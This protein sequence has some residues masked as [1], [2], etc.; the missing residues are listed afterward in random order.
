[1]RN[2][3]ESI[4]ILLRELKT[5]ETCR[6]FRDF[7]LETLTENSYFSSIFL[8][9]FPANRLLPFEV[10]ASDPLQVSGLKK[11]I[12][13]LDT[14]YKSFREIESINLNE[15]RSTLSISSDFVTRAY[16]A[17]EGLYE[18][19]HLINSS[20]FEIKALIGPHI[21]R[22]LQQLP[23]TEK[24]ESPNQ[25]SKKKL[26]QYIPENIEQKMVDTLVA[27][28]K[29][30]PD[31]KLAENEGPAKLSKLVFNLPFYFK[32]L[33]K[34]L[35]TSFEESLKESSPNLLTYQ[36]HFRENT[37]IMQ[38]HFATIVNSEGLSLFP[39]YFGVAKQLLI[40]SRELMTTAAPLTKIGHEK[41]LARLK[42]IRQTLLPAVITEI[43]NVEEMMALKPG[44]LTER[45]IFEM[46][47]YYQQLVNQVNYIAAAAG[48]IEHT[49][50]HLDTWYGKT[51]R[52]LF[53]GDTSNFA[54]GVPLEPAA[55]L[56]LLYNDEFVDQLRQNQIRRI[57]NL[58]LLE[59]ELLE[60]EAD[61]LRQFFAQLEFYR[62]LYLLPEASDKLVKDI[63]TT[64]SVNS[65]LIRRH[66]V[67][68][69]PRIQHSL[70]KF[71]R[72]LEHKSLN[73]VE[74]LTILKEV[75][76]C[77][78]E[79]FQSITLSL[80][81]ADFRRKRIEQTIS[82]SET[83][84]AKMQGEA[85]SLNFSP[86][87][88]FAPL[89][90]TTPQSAE[91]CYEKQLDCAIWVHN[92]KIAE[93][94]CHEFD[95]YLEKLSDDEFA[96][97]QLAVEQ[98]AVLRRLYKDFQAL[99]LAAEEQREKIMLAEEQERLETDDSL[100]EWLLVPMKLDINTELVK[101]LR[102]EQEIANDQPPLNVK[103]LRE[104]CSFIKNKFLKMHLEKGATHLNLYRNWNKKNKIPQL[105]QLISKP[106]TAL[107]ELKILKLS[108][109]IDDYIVTDLKPFLKKN[110]SPSLFELI[111]FNENERFFQGLHRDMPQVAI[112][113]RLLNSLYSIQNILLQLESLDE[114]ASNKSTGLLVIDK[115]K[116]FLPLFNTSHKIINL[117]FSFN[118][119]YSH[120]E[121]IRK[122]LPGEV[123]ISKG[124]ELLNFLQNQAMVS[125]HLPP[126]EFL[127][128]K[129]NENT[130]IDMITAWQEQQNFLRGQRISGHLEVK[131]SS[132]PKKKVAAVN[133]SALEPIVLQ[134][135]QIQAKLEKLTLADNLEANQNP[136]GLIREAI[137]KEAKFL[138]EEIHQLKTISYG[139]NSV[140]NL[141]QVANKINLLLT[142][143][144]NK[145]HHLLMD[146]FQKPNELAIDLIA[147]LQELEFDFGLKPG[148][149]C[150]PLD[151]K[152]NN[153]YKKTVVG[154]YSGSQQRQGL[155]LLANSPRAQK[156]LANEQERLN[157]LAD[158]KR[159]EE[160]DEL[161]N[162]L[163]DNHKNM[164]S[165]YWEMDKLRWSGDLTIEALA[166][167]GRTLANLMGEPNSQN[168]DPRKVS[169]ANIEELIKK[170]FLQ[171][172]EKLQPYLYQID[173]QYN[174][175]RFLRNLETMENFRDAAL[176]IINLEAALGELI[177]AQQITHQWQIG[178]CKER[179]NYFFEQFK[180][181]EQAE[182]Q[183]LAK[184]KKELLIHYGKA[185]IERGLGSYTELFFKKIQQKLLAIG[186]EQF[187]TLSW[188]DNI[189]STIK[190]SMPNLI[191]KL[192]ALS[193]LKSLYKCLLKLRQVD[194]SIQ[195][196][197]NL[198]YLN[199][200]QQQQ[201]AFLRSY[202]RKL[203]TTKK[204]LRAAKVK[205]APHALWALY[206]DEAKIQNKIVIA[207][208]LLEQMRS[209]LLSKPHNPTKP[210]PQ[211]EKIS[212][213][214]SLMEKLLAKPQTNRV[215]S[216]PSKR[217]Q[218]VKNEWNSADFRKI[219]TDD[220][221][222][223]FKRLLKKLWEILSGR[224]QRNRFFTNLDQILTTEDNTR[225]HPG[226][227]VGNH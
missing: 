225:S 186:K 177:K 108:A 97:G 26:H 80:N 192:S 187:A 120:F 11:I 68:L 179:I 189:E 1:M 219:L 35:D 118:E 66:L 202:R 114:K 226:P 93:K 46:N 224:P 34:L 48:I 8:A 30:L 173:S 123:V 149:L 61:T 207:Y 88:A 182:I 52:Q 113:K 40:H 37:E 104:H 196:L 163:M 105:Q 91:E 167:I 54:I 209:H 87:K 181:E 157:R 168:S 29:E 83:V 155:K 111:P 200:A 22:I 201:L 21:A 129:P 127:Q 131:K 18:A 204:Q 56:G 28:I 3:V 64:L 152:F 147:S 197:Q 96:I 62:D 158:P 198:P 121:E 213:I 12:N 72:N 223:F 63:K 100:D 140:K 215:T 90:I 132:Q 188:E 6:I 49:G 15:T 146:Y 143:L 124:L 20:G 33:Q 156:L 205:V 16:K 112:Y 222:N 211:Q 60:I 220:S 194:Q 144:G 85:T 25:K 5:A 74:E 32:E 109:K 44:I 165:L 41:A 203:F 89:L 162:L 184:F 169:L 23:F 199:L 31:E 58:E 86:V 148:I 151:E 116:N 166:S 94:S 212:A 125:A 24:D 53:L 4:V 110:L 65:A 84:I 216:K 190:E 227:L 75:L 126:L 185:F 69:E 210:L 43:E 136:S 106:K 208:E 82:H 9:Y 183:Q 81:E 180:L 117:L 195:S 217:F 76:A 122:I 101:A 78:T 102:E 135:L 10:S 145:S 70:G 128:K 79:V 161:K 17:A 115:A 27:T 103:K 139:P 47:N 134:L 150:K 57:K 13:A 7:L 51:I 36:Q 171:Y 191:K 172:Y 206:E 170:L 178:L 2:S 92:L 39:S 160:A 42:E 137:V 67:N 98:K 133:D 214:N 142:N 50:F 164:Q 71:L 176:K 141:L 130:K 99:S 73:R 55:D 77:K 159:V 174:R 14:A 95:H 218:N 221:D 119:A 175:D 107:A 154:L 153:F 59:L 38:Q 193:P 45:V 138:V 19:L